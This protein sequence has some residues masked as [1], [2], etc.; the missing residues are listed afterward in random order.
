[1]KK[2]LYRLYLKCKFISYSLLG[3]FTLALILGIAY[4]NNRFIETSIT[5]MTFFIFRKLFEKQYHS[6][7]L[8]LC[9]AISIIV[10]TI[11]SL[12]ELPLNISILFS[13]VIAFIITTISYFVKD[14]L[15]SL[16][17]LKQVSKT[18]KKA[19]EN[20]TLKEMLELMPNI[21]TDI[22]EIV[23]GYLHKDKT[24][25]AYGYARSKNISEPLVYKYLKKVRDEYKSLSI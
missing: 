3:I 9:S 6:K 19:L 7:S 4:L 23:Y 1:M 22:I 8:L 14:Y 10:F 24:L 15:D 12:I 21:K 2:K 17:K 11:V 13:I 18:R 25:N 16:E 20:L 5:A